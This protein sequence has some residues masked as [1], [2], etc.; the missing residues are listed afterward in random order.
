MITRQPAVLFVRVPA[1]SP[2]IKGDWNAWY[3]Q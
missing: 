1:V 3:G 2:E